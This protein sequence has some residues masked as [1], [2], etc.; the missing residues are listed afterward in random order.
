MEALSG[1]EL[2]GNFP[3]AK[4]DELKNQQAAI[5]LLKLQELKQIAD[6]SDE[7]INSCKELI[8]SASPTVS[9]NVLE[10]WMETVGFKWHDLSARIEDRE[11][12]IDAAL[13]SL[14]SY[15]DAYDSLLNWLE[16]TEEL[17]NNQKPPSADFKLVKAQLQNHDFQLKLLDDKLPRLKFNK[18]LY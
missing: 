15:N 16:E 2:F 5:T 4:I 3:N 1:T 7:I 12:Q 11:R 6:K 13:Q 17:L 10:E 14:G 18:I 8:R 9:T